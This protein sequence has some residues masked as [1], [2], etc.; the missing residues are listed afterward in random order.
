[1]TLV[2]KCARLFNPSNHLWFR[3]IPISS[4]FTSSPSSSSSSSS[5]P[6]RIE[7]GL[8]KRGIEDI[9]DIT[10]IQSLVVPNNSSSTIINNNINKF[11]TA[12]LVTRGQELVQIHYEG[13]TITSADELYHTVWE[14]YTDQLSVC[15]PV[16]GQFIELD[17]TTTTTTTTHNHG[18]DYIDDT[19]VLIANLITTKEEWESAR[20]DNLLVEETCYLEAIRNLPRGKFAE[21]E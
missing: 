11:A 8:T 18:D 19:T 13:H 16:E 21:Q 5:S 12:N 1:M 6:I 2:A 14:T 9:G 17:A 7:I 4:S 10:S 3:A 20:V 15:S